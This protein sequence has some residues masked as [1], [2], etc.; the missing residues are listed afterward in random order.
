MVVRAVPGALSPRHV[1]MIVSFSTKL[2]STPVNSSQLC[3]RYQQHGEPINKW[4]QPRFWIF[5]SKQMHQIVASNVLLEFV[6]K[7]FQISKTKSKKK[8]QQIQKI[9][10]YMLQNYLQHLIAVKVLPSNILWKT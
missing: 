1:L 2:Q 9:R 5:Y 10:K 4:S 8:Q 6:C 3:Q 7:A